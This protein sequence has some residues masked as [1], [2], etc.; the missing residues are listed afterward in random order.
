MARKSSYRGKCGVCGRAILSTHGSVFYSPGKYHRVHDD[1]APLDCY[2]RNRFPS[3]DQRSRE[4]IADLERTLGPVEEIP[5]K[6]AGKKGGVRMTP[7]KDGDDWEEASADFAPIVTLSEIGDQ[8][9]GRLIESRSVEV[10]DPDSKKEGATKEAQIYDFE[11]LSA[12]EDID[13]NAV[14]VG[15]KF[16][17]WGSWKLNQTLPGNE[18]RETRIAF[19]GMVETDN[20]REVG[21]YKVEFHK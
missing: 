16:S 6:A 2:T 18:G 9:H 17:V 20:G 14:D 8:I 11:A 3:A 1:R 7:A 10:T 5:A 19:L 4:A 21:K 15:S 13:G 12:L